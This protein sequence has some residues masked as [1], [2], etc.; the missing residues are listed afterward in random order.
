MVSLTG[1]GLYQH[2][3]PYLLPNNTVSNHSG[4]WYMDMARRLTTLVDNSVVISFPLVSALINSACHTGI[5]DVIIPFP[6]PVIILPTF[7]ANPYQQ[8]NP[9]GQKKNYT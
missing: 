8:A 6:V 3:N 5:D 1:T 7:V 9:L 4:R 2:S